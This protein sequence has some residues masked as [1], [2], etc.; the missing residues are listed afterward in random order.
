[1]IFCVE[2]RKKNNWPDSRTVSMGTC[3]VC[4]TRTNCYEV[5]S[6][7]LPEGSVKLDKYETVVEY[8][9]NDIVNIDRL[10]SEWT[11]LNCNIRST[12]KQRWIKFI[13]EIDDTKTKEISKTTNKC[14][15]NG[16]CTSNL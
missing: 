9:I 6:I 4:K 8:L 11:K 14:A 2:C 1:M 16:T 12:I 3:E 13:K 5:S 10:G 15:C 7:L